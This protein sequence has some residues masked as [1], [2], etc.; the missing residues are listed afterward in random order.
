[1]SFRDCLDDFYYNIFKKHFQTD[2]GSEDLL[3]HYTNPS[4]FLKIIT[5]RKIRITNVNYFDDR[6]EYDYGIRLAIN[7]LKEKAKDENYDPEFC[8]FVYDQILRFY[9]DKQKYYI[10][11]TCLQPCNEYLW[12]TYAGQDGCVLS[13]NKK[14]LCEALDAN[15]ICAKTNRDGAFK[16][17]S[18]EVIYAKVI[19]NMQK[20]VEIITELI[21]K[22]HDYWKEKQS[23]IE[24]GGFLIPSLPKYLLMFKTAGFNKEDEFRII[25]ENL[26]G[27]ES[28]YDDSKRYI[29]MDWDDRFPYILNKVILNVNDSYFNNMLKL[30][31]TFKKLEYEKTEIK[32]RYQP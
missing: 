4:A 9:L 21:K 11:S 19:Y 14:T 27:S 20:Q 23:E 30:D 32:L 10:F 17:C 31:E 3:Y 28:I 25:I 8:I 13:F 22:L 6:L 18:Y 29:H 1:M 2:C 15:V 26:E 7:I 16:S 24:I 12:D 5:S